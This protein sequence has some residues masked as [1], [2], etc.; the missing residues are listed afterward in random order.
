MKCSNNKNVT[1]QATLLTAG[2]WCWGGWPVH[3]SFL[4]PSDCALHPDYISPLWKEE[5]LFSS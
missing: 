1:G 3:I 5:T 2:A 4:M